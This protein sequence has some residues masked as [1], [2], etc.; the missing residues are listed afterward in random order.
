FWTSDD[1]CYAIQTIYKSYQPDNDSDLFEYALDQTDYANID[2]RS[3][4]IIDSLSKRQLMYLPIATK[5]RLI[6]ELEAGW[7][8]GDETDAL[9]KIY[10]SYQ[11]AMDSDLFEYA[12]DKTDYA[13]VDDRALDIVNSL[14]NDQIRKMPGYIKKR[15]IDELE[16]GNSY[17]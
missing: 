17:R 6:E 4:L 1:E 9:K 8:S 2:D 14:S 12:L 16:A 11:P 3:H 5:K 15:L 13:N 10:A 7:T